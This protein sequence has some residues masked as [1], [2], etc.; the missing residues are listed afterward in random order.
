MDN[1]GASGAGFSGMAVQG[2][3]L[4]FTVNLKQIL[5]LLGERGEAAEQ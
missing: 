4:I 3:M 5:R 1:H 2:A